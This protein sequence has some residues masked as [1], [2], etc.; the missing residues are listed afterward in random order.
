MSTSPSQH[1]LLQR[2]LLLTNEQG[3]YVFDA[4]LRI[5]W[6]KNTDST[7]PDRLDRVFSA[8]VLALCQRVL[9]EKTRAE[10]T[11]IHQ[12][13]T[14]RYRAQYFPTSGQ[15][16]AQGVL[17][18]QDVTSV[19]VPRERLQRTIER[20]REANQLALQREKRLEGTINGA[21]EGILILN[22]DSSINFYN[23]VAQRLLG[24]SAERE[25]NF[26]DLIL[27]EDREPILAFLEQAD[28]EAQTLKE[29]VRFR[30]I[31][32]H[33]VFVGELSLS[34]IIGQTIEFVAIIEDISER[35]A[36][37]EQLKKANEALK[38]RER[39]LSKNAQ[40]LTRANQHLENTLTALKNT[41]VNL[42]QAEKMSSLGQLTAG[43]A[44]ELNN[45][46]NFMFAGVQA[47]QANFEDLLEFI[48]ATN[49][50][51]E[52]KGDPKKLEEKL[53]T[54]R[55]KREELEVPFLQK[56]TERM[57]RDVQEG[58]DRTAN[59]VK[60][61]LTFSRMN[62]ESYQAINIH[63]SIRSTLNILRGQL[64]GR[65]QVFE[66]FGEDVPLIEG[67]AGKL[68]QVLM[69]VIVNAADAIEDKGE[70]HIRTRKTLLHD[71]KAIQITI[72]DTGNGIPEAVRGK[73]FDPFFTTKDVGKGTGL[74]LYISHGIIER[75]QGTIEVESAPKQGTTFRITLPVAQNT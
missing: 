21:S 26:L 63:D 4:D 70:I 51:L 39:E 40:K 19:D 7:R 59:I 50:L 43:I 71:Q 74:G 22:E 18:V 20:L 27:E 33:Q 38:R 67:L 42:I 32:N 17:F 6:S 13:Q 58:A 47:L 49:Q 66:N 65:I 60:G 48:D 44:H 30:H 35:K 10:L 16:E 57:L 36:A 69:N 29:E 23:R 45:P 61:L 37:E 34:K 75:H 2:L 46:I 52:E 24:F 31:T 56:D 14:L 3:I 53:N 15:E 28:P 73:I 64:R 11:E 9:H 1:S 54:L 12:E 8:P 5:K 41:Q 55:Q 25:K 62:E 72:R 68:N